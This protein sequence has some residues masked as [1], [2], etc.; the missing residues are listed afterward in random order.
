MWRFGLARWR[1]PLSRRADIPLYHSAGRRAAVARPPPRVV[2]GVV[3][4][5]GM[6]YS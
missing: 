3:G 6:D 5:G 1:T 2:T 4:P